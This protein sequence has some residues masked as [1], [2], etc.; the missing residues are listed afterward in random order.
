MNPHLTACIALLALGL[1][2]SSPALAQYNADYQTNIISG[3]LSNWAGDYYVGSNTLANALWIQ[4]GGVLSNRQGFV[5]YSSGSSNNTVWIADIGSAWNN[6]SNLIIGYSGMGNS[7]A[8]H[9]GGRVGNYSGYLGY[10]GGRNNSACVADTNSVWRNTNY[11]YVGYFGSGNSLT[12][13][14]GGR[15]EDYAGYLGYATSSSSNRAWI[16]GGGSCWSNRTSLIVGNGGSANSLVV[17]N[18]GCVIGSDGYVGYSSASN[19]AIVTGSGAL[20]SNSVSL[21]VGSLGSSNCLWVS[22]GGR[23]VNSTGYI[24][25]TSGSNNCAVVT[26]SNAVWTTSDDLFLGYY[27][28]SSR[29]EISDGGRVDD[30]TGYLGYNSASSN[31]CTVVAG[32]GSVWSNRASLLIGN[33]GG[34]NCLVISNSGRVVASAAYIGYLSASNQALV[35]SGGVL[36]SSLVA[37]GVNSGSNDLRVADGGAV[38]TDSLIV[39][40]NSGAR[41]NQVWLEGGYLIVTNLAGVGSL[42]VGQGGQGTLTLN[43]GVLTA[44]R[45][46]LT[47]G[48]DSRMAFN[49]GLLN[50]RQTVLAN[51]TV[52]AVGDGTTPAEFHLQ[53]GVHSFAN[54][55]RLRSNARLTGCG[56]IAGEVLVDSDAEVATS[57][58]QVLVFTGPITNNGTLRAING[59][60]LEFN[61]TVVNNGLIDVMNGSASFHAGFINNGIYLNATGDWDGDGMPNQQELLAGTDPTNQASVFRITDVTPELNSLRVSWII[62]GLR[63]N[64]LQVNGNLTNAF[65]NLFT[66][67]NP[68]TEAIVTNYLHAG[69]LTNA[70]MRYYRVRLVP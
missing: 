42:V 41:S 29:L 58:G 7:L 49:G 33:G 47:N 11:L 63:T 48:A 40:L 2:A 43:G 6:A 3:V 27:G 64:A 59:T 12:L 28:G 32:G 20:W 8:I 61:G 46:A 60:T 70:A 17:S 35:T 19:W 16:T 24:G 23:V 10:S 21:T 45:L 30:N 62:G 36:R 34:G 50:S 14:N 26:G 51:G 39:G 13:T 37:V 55:L 57:C 53:G 1:A 38:V 66:A 54:G 25:Y 5:G 52:F 56:T 18:R 22:D 9:G 44:D 31:N 68:S 67:A 69:T 15:V 4:A 65:T